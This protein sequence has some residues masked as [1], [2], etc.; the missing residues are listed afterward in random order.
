MVG[1]VYGT[2]KIVDYYQE[3]IKSSIITE[4]NAYLTDVKNNKIE[5][6]KN[7]MLDLEKIIEISDKKI[8]DYENIRY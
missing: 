3:Q 5:K 7:E 2:I 8:D 6:I 1:I 4:Y